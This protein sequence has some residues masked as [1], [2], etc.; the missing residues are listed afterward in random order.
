MCIENVKWFLSQILI[1]IISWIICFPPSPTHM[2]MEKLLDIK[3]K[4]LKGKKTHFK[5]FVL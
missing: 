3:Y 4:F 2:H 1:A 5:L